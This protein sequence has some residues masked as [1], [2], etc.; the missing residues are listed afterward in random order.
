MKYSTELMIKRIIKKII[1][2]PVKIFQHITAAD[3][4]DSGQWSSPYEKKQDS[5]DK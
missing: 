5:E 1:R 4:D 3:H 2:T